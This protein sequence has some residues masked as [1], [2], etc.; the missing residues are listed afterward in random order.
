[1]HERPF[2]I[3]LKNSSKQF[4]GLPMRVVACTKSFF[5][6]FKCRNIHILVST[7]DKEMLSPL[8]NQRKFEKLEDLNKHFKKSINAKY[9]LFHS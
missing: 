1:M 4:F 7:Y 5:F 2:G 9:V 3:E 6:Y 8:S